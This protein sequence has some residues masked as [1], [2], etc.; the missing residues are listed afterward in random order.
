MELTEIFFD[1]NILKRREIEDFSDLKFNNVFESFLDFLGAE[2]LL[3]LYRINVCEITL[4]E[5]KKQISEE[6][7]KSKEELSKNYKKLKNIHTIKMDI[8]NNN[9]YERMEKFFLDYFETKNIKKIDIPKNKEIFNKIINRAINKEKPFSGKDGESDKGFKDVILWESILEYAKKSQSKRFMLVTKNKNDFPLQLKDEFKMQTHKDIR[10]YYEI[11]DLQK[12]VIN[13]QNMKQID[14]LS[15]EKIDKIELANAINEYF[16]INEVEGLVGKD[17]RIEN[18]INEGNNLYSFD[19]VEEIN[20]IQYC[21]RIE[22]TYID[23][24]IEIDKVI[25]CV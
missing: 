18:F 24:K 5:L 14:M 7:Y 8:D 20:D 17:F 2:D 3:E 21:W 11:A 25:Q 1:T 12:F 19:L 15:I 13:E 22:T 9:F 6:Y 23:N 16:L 10:I 4:E